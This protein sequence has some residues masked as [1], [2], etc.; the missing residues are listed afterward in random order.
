MNKRVVLK[1]LETQ[2][3]RVRRLRRL[4]LKELQK[5]TY[6]T[7]NS[8]KLNKERSKL[9]DEECDL[10]SAIEEISMFIENRK[11]LGEKVSLFSQ[12]SNF[13]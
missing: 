2:L 11:E 10:I 6:S 1:P 5:C 13:N 8:K 9:W 4:Y 12:L 3:K 7:R